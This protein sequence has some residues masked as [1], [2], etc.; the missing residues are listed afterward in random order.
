MPLP[1]DAEVDYKHLWHR[2]DETVA[3]F[4]LSDILTSMRGLIACLLQ[5]LCKGGS[6]ACVLGGFTE[7][8]LKLNTVDLHLVQKLALTLPQLFSAQRDGGL[9]TSGI[10]FPRGATQRPKASANPFL[11]SSSAL[12]M[13]P[14]SQQIQGTTALQCSWTCLRRTDACI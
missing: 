14:T 6:C 7:T 5:K 3:V 11:T 12:D 4:G 9:S 10:I 1:E 8:H 2:Q 13:S